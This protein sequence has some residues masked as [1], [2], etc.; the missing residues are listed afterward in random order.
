[1]KSLLTCNYEQCMCESTYVE[2]LQ[3]L[4]KALSPPYTGL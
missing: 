1:M 3:T 4:N 2:M